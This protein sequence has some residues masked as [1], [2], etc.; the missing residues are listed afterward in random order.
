M[1]W[2]SGW[3]HRWP[4][5]ITEESGSNLFNHQ[6]GGIAIQGNDPESPNY[7]DFSVFQDGGLDVRFTDTDGI[8]ELS[9]WIRSA[10]MT[11][12]LSKFRILPP[13]AARGFGILMMLQEL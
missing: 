5:T 13:R 12:L 8:T 10:I 2:L 3:P 4:V 6:V 11:I 9:F 7:I 1:A